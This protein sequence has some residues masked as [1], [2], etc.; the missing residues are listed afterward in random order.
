MKTSQLILTLALAGTM[1]IALAGNLS[2]AELTTFNSGDAL[3]STDMNANFDAAQADIND[4]DTRT[5]SNTNTLSTHSGNASAH[6]TPGALAPMSWTNNNDTFTTF[7]NT[8]PV[9]LNTLNINVPSDGTLVIHATSSLANGDT[10]SCLM[11][12]WPKLDATGIPARIPS[13]VRLDDVTGQNWGTLSYVVSTTVTA[14]AHTVTNES[15]PTSCGG[16]P[17]YSSSYAALNVV[18]YPGSQGVIASPPLALS[19]RNTEASSTSEL[20]GNVR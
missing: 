4:N 15:T 12:I 9:D 17:S 5:T 13:I 6:H 10:A 7:T 3:S 8:T 20:E 2:D 14:G 19:N 11:R 18:F 16:T 1:N